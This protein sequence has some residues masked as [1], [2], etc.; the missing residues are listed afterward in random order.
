[1]SSGAFAQI[2]GGGRQDMERTISGEAL[3]A[4][5]SRFDERLDNPDPES[6]RLG[7]ALKSLPL[8]DIFEVILSPMR[9]I[10]VVPK[11]S[12]PVMTDER[13]RFEFIGVEPG[14]YKLIFARNGYAK[15]QYGQRT[16]AGGGVPLTLSAGQAR[17][18]IVMK[19]MP[20]GA[21]SGS[22]RDSAGEPVVGVPVQVVRFSYDETGRKHAQPVAGTMTDDRG[23]YRM[24]YLPP[25][26]YYLR[27]GPQE[28]SALLVDPG[29]RA[30]LGAYSSLNAKPQTYAMTYYPGVLEEERA[31]AIEVPPGADLQRVDLFVDA[32]R[33]H[34]V[35]GRVVDPASGKPPPAVMFSMRMQTDSLLPIDG[36]RSGPSYSAADGTFEFQNVTPG[37]YLLTAQNRGAAIPIADPLGMSPAERTAFFEATTAAQ[38]AQPR[39]VALVRVLDAD[40]EG[41]VL[42]MDT[43]I[44][45]T[46][47]FRIGTADPNVSLE[48]HLLNIRLK[49]PGRT[50]QWIYTT[51]DPQFRMASA[52][53]TFRIDN[54][55]PGEYSLSISGLP[56]GFYVKEARLGDTDVLNGRVTIPSSNTGVLEIVLSP[57]V[58]TITGEAF[59]AADRP[60]AGA[61]VVLIPSQNRERPELFLPV[62][63]DSSGRFSIPSVAPGE[64][65]LAAWEVMEPY[66][67]FNP[68]WIARA[69]R[70]GKAVQVTESSR[71]A[72]SI[73]VIPAVER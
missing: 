59:D 47:R 37:I 50:S 35:R 42:T 69:E 48:Y 25:G 19:M 66:S 68:E 49:T 45:I 72:V 30:L 67:Y 24:F 28:G 4:M 62:T 51:T 2:I 11:A 17:T 54:V 38:R 31:A 64:Y 60:M 61:Q 56:P 13:G 44:P 15:Q 7:T 53:G 43:S 14:T 33:T 26:R 5:L 52:D 34:S 40:V 10:A 8:A 22:V 16:A 32:Q 71:Q 27:A 12:P 57:N 41:V 29:L 36:M 9:G 21:I 1:V 39:A 65:I 18:D 70:S 20:T 55:L 23:E 6:V 73:T 58:G 46:G 63:T 3:D